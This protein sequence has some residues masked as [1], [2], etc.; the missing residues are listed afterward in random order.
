MKTNIRLIIILIL[1]TSI[2]KGQDSD[3]SVNPR[4]IYSV[5]L[6][7][8]LNQIREKNLLPLVH[9]GFVTELSFETEKIKSSLR[10]FQFTFTYSRVKTSIEEMS[11]SGNIK[12]GLN[13]S[14][15]FLVFQKTNFRYYLG[16]QASLCYSF[17]MFPNWDDS[18]GYWADYMSFGPNNIFSVSLRHECEWFAAINFSLLGLFSRPKEIRPF[19]MDDS[20]FGGIFKA[21]NSNVE[22]GLMNRLFQIN[23]RTEYRFPVFVNKREAITFNT[24]IIRISGINGQPVFQ[25]INMLGLKIML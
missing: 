25:I 1:T 7:S 11:K 9:K 21:L 8:G 24:N 13:Y 10:Q 20:S 2:I 19:K 6:Q 23:I 5:N 16:P 17:M 18:H 14:F 22:P 3:S 15:N 12:L 4:K